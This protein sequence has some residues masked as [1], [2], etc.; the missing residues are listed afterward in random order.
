MNWKFWKPSSE[1]DLVRVRAVTAVL[2]GERE[3]THVGH[4]GK[5]VKEHEGR[6]NRDK[7]VVGHYERLRRECALC[8]SAELKTIS[9]FILREDQEKYGQGGFPE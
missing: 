8:G 2:S 4:W 1:V 9:T 5:W 7:L 6:L 3:C